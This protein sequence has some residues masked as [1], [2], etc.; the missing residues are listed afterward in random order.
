MNPQ[1]FL[2]AAT[3]VLLAIGALGVSGRLGAMSRASFFHPPAW[4]N[5]FHL[6]LGTF[7]AWARLGGSPRVQASTTAVATVMGLT[8]GSLGLLLGPGA[9]RRFKQPQLAD[10]SDHLAHLGV[11]LTALWA[12]LAGRGRDVP[13]AGKRS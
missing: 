10:P 7:L 13:A 8:V 12:W 1:R 3:A 4:I 5:W 11:G 2:T 9:A 6:G